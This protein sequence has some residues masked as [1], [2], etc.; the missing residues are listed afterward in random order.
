MDAFLNFMRLYFIS[1]I[2][3]YASVFPLMCFY[4]SGR[5]KRS[6]FILRLVLLSIAYFAAGTAACFLIRNSPFTDMNVAVSIA[7]GYLYVLLFAFIPVAY[8]IKFKQAVF[9]Y[10]VCYSVKMLVGT[11]LD[12]AAMPLASALEYYVYLMVSISIQIVLCW[13]IYFIVYKLYY[14]KQKRA[15]NVYEPNTVVVIFCFIIF[16]GT[17]TLDSGNTDGSSNISYILIT[18]ACYLLIIFVQFGFLEQSSLKM[19]IEMNERLWKEREKQLLLTKENFDLISVKCHDIKHYL[20]LIEK[21]EYNIP[22]SEMQKLTEA[23][24]IYDCFIK[25]GCDALDSI[26]TDRAIFCKHNGIRLT[27]D[28]QGNALAFLSTTDAVA[29][30]GNAVENA[31]EAVMKLDKEDRFISITGKEA[32]DFYLI[33]IENPYDGELNVKNN[34]PATTKESDKYHGFGIKSMKMTVK[35]YGG[36][37]SISTD[38]NVFSLKILFPLS[39]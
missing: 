33:S 11:I 39:R 26:L 38:D 8:K 27:C 25:T 22:Q 20:S 15:E 30:F 6:R 4:L 24:E 14:S 18:V 34:S 23:M 13:I 9:D 17:L 16:V 1:V 37:L 10:I 36:N 29:L 35:K 2:S 31:I 21:G 3:T 19:N 12:F 7:Y 28:I 5:K 32:K